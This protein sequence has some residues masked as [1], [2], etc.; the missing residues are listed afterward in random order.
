M[1]RSALIFFLLGLSLP[2]YSAGSE[3]VDLADAGRSIYYSAMR[4]D[5]TAVRATVQ[6]DVPLPDGAG[7][8]VSCHRRSGLGLAEGG[9]RA[10]DITGPSLFNARE[11]P[12]ERAAYDDA[13]LT[14]AIVA[15][16]DA[17]GESLSKLMPRY[18]LSADDAAA[19]ATYLR[20]LG[21]ES[22]PG[23]T[24]TE[25]VIATIITPDSSEEERQALETIIPAYIKVKNGGSRQERRR[26]VASA[27]HFYGIKRYQAY[28]EWKHSFWKLEG[29]PET[30]QAQLQSLYLESP[31]FAILSGSVGHHSEIVH[32]FCEQNE[33][34]CVLPMT[35]SPPAGETGFY[36]LY[37]SAGTRLEAD[38]IG[39]YLADAGAGTGSPVLLVHND[40]N[41]GIEAQAMVLQRIAKRGGGSIR[42]HG[43]APGRIPTVTEWKRLLQ[44]NAIDTL[45]LLL[46]EKQLE[47]LMLPNFDARS[48]PATIVTAEAFTDW[49]RSRNVATIANRIVHV[50]PYSLEKPGRSQFPREEV[51]LKSR[52]IELANDVSAA[53]VLFAC[54]ALGMALADIQSNFSREYL[55]E[56]LEHALDNSLLTSLYPRTTLGPDQ[57]YLSR[58]AYLGRLSYQGGQIV[59]ADGEWM[60]P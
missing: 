41:D 28:R 25:L 15:G 18:Q 35:D 54:K 34:A 47:N 46:S 48:L 51:W 6:Q 60:Q 43:I 36:S 20:Q 10:L 50:Y 24:E 31:P 26:S 56:S 12:P 52:G 44:T 53:K 23:V 49:S 33:I 4:L 40:D 29:D 55:L 9:A 21:T 2:D 42:T 7:A 37:F 11:V 27:R 30:W 13:L 58:G 57:R 39:N 17:N 8:C 38:V 3:A 22:V 19:I 59:L 45:V 32:E 1:R 5:G 14:R 16:I